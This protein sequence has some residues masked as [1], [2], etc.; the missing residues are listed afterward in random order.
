MLVKFALV[1]LLLHSNSVLSNPIEDKSDQL[2][3]ASCNG[4]FDIYFVLDL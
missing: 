2:F 1:L 3:E 4:A